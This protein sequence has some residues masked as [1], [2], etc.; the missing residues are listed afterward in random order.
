MKNHKID[1]LIYAI[2]A[3]KYHEQ[4]KQDQDISIKGLLIFLA[5]F[6]IMLV[7]QIIVNGI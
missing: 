3:R 4:K 7:L 5:F 1:S 6:L 2:K